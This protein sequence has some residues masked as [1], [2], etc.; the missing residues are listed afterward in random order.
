MAIIART[1]A[2]FHGVQQYDVGVTE[3]GT[4]S[5]DLYHIPAMHT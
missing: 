4:C 5:S 2:L 3:S 1:R